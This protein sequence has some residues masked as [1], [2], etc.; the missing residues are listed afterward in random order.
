MVLEQ[1]SAITAYEIGPSEFCKQLH[2]K[3]L[4]SILLTLKSQIA[5]TSCYLA[6]LDQYMYYWITNTCF[7]KWVCSLLV[8]I[9]FDKWFLVFNEPGR[10]S[11]P[12]WVGQPT[13]GFWDVKSLL[14]TAWR[15]IFINSTSAT[16]IMERH[17]E[18]KCDRWH[19]LRV[20]CRVNGDGTTG[21]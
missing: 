9:V 1:S 3:C 16:A 15:K 21:K 18:T 8:H 17:F 11:K 10:E 4:L 2:Y 12:Q 7:I 14:D 6:K 19:R 5:K 20:D 13:P